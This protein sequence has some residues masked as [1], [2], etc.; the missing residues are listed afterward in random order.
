MEKKKRYLEGFRKWKRGEAAQ[1]E[2]ERRWGGRGRKGLRVHAPA[3]AGQHR[4]GG[5]GA[6]ALGRESGR[7]APERRGGVA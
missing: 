1:Q 2:S 4:P 6:G 3:S 5:G 7:A